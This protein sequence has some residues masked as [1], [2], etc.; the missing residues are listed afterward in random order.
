[1]ESLICEIHILGHMR[2]LMTP[3]KHNLTDISGEYVA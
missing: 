1:M 2:T 3:W